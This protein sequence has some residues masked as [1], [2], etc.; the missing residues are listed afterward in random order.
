VWN[1]LVKVVSRISIN[2]QPHLVVQTKDGKLF[3]LNKSELHEA[4]LNY[5][6]SFAADNT[7]QLN[8][9]EVNPEMASL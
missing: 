8:L 6:E 9:E 7:S 4:A 5:L 3:I 2:D 1:D